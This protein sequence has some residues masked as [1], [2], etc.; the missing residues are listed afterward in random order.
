MKH[1]D[2]CIQ[3]DELKKYTA[4]AFAVLYAWMGWLTIDH[5]SLKYDNAKLLTEVKSLAEFTAKTV[6]ELKNDFKDMKK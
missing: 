1:K 6:D 2:E 3:L 4:V 5:L